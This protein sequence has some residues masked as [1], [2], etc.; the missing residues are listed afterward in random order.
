MNCIWSNF[1]GPSTGSEEV[2]RAPIPHKQ[3]TLV[4]QEVLTFGFRG[5]PRKRAATS[6]FDT[7]R[8][9]QAETSKIGFTLN[10]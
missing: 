7:F 3:E 9:F 1:A 4:E 10:L 2:V 8:D 5:K 6:V